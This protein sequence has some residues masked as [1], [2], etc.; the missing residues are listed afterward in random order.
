MRYLIGFALLL[1]MVVFAK[2]PA[3]PEALSSAN[4]AFVENRSATDND[5][6]K[7]YKELKKW[8]RFTLVK[9]Q[10]TTDIHISLSRVKLWGYQGI[11]PYKWEANT[12][13]IEDRFGVLLYTDTTKEG[14]INPGRL[15]SNLSLKMKRK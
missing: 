4:T 9:D 14:F 11:Q 1:P 15:V 12:I 2:D 13:N 10:H 8:G 7:F 6:N 3:L 5:F